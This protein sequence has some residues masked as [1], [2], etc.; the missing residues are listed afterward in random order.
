MAHSVTEA[1][2]IVEDSG[3]LVAHS[4]TEAPKIIEDSGVLV[5]H[6]VTEAP[7]IIEDSGV[8]VAHS[9]TEAPKIIED[10]GITS[11]SIIFRNCIDENGGVVSGGNCVVV[12]D[13]WIDMKNGDTTFD[14]LCIVDR[15]AYDVLSPENLYK[16][17][18]S[19]VEIRNA[20]N[21]KAAGLIV[22]E[23]FVITS[24]NIIA[25]D[26]SIYNL[27]TI[28]GKE[29]TGRAVRVNLSKN[30]ALIMLDD[31]TEYT[32]LSL[33]LDLPK[34]GQIGYLTLGILN[35]DNFEDGENYIDSDGKIAGYRYSEDKGSEIMVDTFV[36]HV[37]IGGVLIDG[38]GTI[39]GLAHTGKKTEN[40]MDL[41]LPTETAL[42]SL[43]LSICE[44]LYEKS[45]PWQQTVYKPVTE[46]IMNSTPKAPEEMKE[47][48][49]K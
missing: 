49:R 46:L 21:Q 7:K 17:R 27:K 39:N 35:V 24:A 38:H 41:F 45:S 26:S 43:G 36:Q 11:D 29:L 3:V 48:E 32:P 13:T 34:I 15:P 10:S 37:T 42:R 25:K 23:N 1:P 31:E 20:A 18:A 30:T 19:I 47:E 28:N 44:K 8:F 6:S 33:N 2:K 22:S 12:D 14:S 4:V 9:V 40:G 16:V 5:S